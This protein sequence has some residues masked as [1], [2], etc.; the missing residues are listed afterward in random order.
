MTGGPPDIVLLGPDWRARTLLRA[1]LVEEGY[2]V[3]RPATVG[4]VV[5]RVT[6]LFRRTAPEGRT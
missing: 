1:Q 5:A 2:E 4:H 3:A 6:L